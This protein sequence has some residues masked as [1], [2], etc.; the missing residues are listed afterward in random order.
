MSNRLRF[1]SS[2]VGTKILIAFSGLALFVFL[3]LHLAGNL[4]ALAGSGAFNEYSHE[5]ISNPFIYV[6]EAG[7]AAI[8]LLHV[9]KTV[10]N[11]IANRRARPVGYH[12]KRW[13]GRT[14]RKSVASSTMIV[15]GGVTFA[16]VVL[17]LKTFKFGP[18]YEVP[19]RPQVRDLYRLLID[20]FQNPLYVVFYV[21]CMIL[22]FL[23]LRHG[24]SSALQSLGI[25]HPRYN[26]IMLQVG[27]IT[28]LLIGAGFAL[29]PVWAYLT[30]GA[31]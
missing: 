13:T 25:N 15:T 22:I 9:F 8:F 6:A 10:T 28:A 12:M 31:G 20:V 2:T 5:L 18:Y 7:L 19:G 3:I 11:W 16:F 1:F 30:G 17:H 29:I 23:H 14:S 4:F 26:A 21:V 27:S 24:L